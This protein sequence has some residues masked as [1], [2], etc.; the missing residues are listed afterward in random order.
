MNLS[1]LA[2]VL[3]ADNNET[4][5][6]VLGTIPEIAIVDGV[7][8]EEGLKS[9]FANV[10]SI[11]KR[12]AMVG[13]N[14]SLWT[15]LLSTVR[16]FLV[17]ETQAKRDITNDVDPEALTPYEVLAKAQNC[18]DSGDLELAVKFMSLLKGLP[19]KLASDWLRESRAYL[20]T[21]QASDFLLA[22]V[23]SENAD[24]FKE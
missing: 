13:D 12:V 17:F 19:R 21:K 20:E 18:I 4:V 2:F 10:K 7:C 24:D 11:C 14:V 9:R 5:Q 15:Y 16:S 6:F 8:T 23:A 22:F 1:N 3:V